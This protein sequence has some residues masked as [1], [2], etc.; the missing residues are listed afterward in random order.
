MNVTKPWFTKSCFGVLGLALVLAGCGGK[1]DMDKINKSI[2]DGLSSQLGLADVAVTCPAEARPLKSGDTFDCEGK[3]KEG[4]KLTIKVTQKDDQGNIAWELSNMEGF[5]SAQ[6]TE[7]AIKSGLKEQ[8]NVDATVSCGDKKLRAA[9][10]G[11]TFDC[12]ATTADGAAHTVTVTET[13]AT[14]KISWAVKDEGGAAAPAETPAP[15]EH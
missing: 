4:G 13:D 12:K 11:D 1:L 10:A 8:A 15:E 14:G 2:A 3:P 7:E 6:K 5:I 9:K